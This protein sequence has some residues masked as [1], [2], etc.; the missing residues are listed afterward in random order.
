MLAGTYLPRAHNVR[1]VAISVAFLHNWSVYKVLEAATWRS[2]PFFTALYIRDLS[3]S[4]DE[5]HSL[6]PFVVAGSVVD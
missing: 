4:L 3:Y 6:G 2:N 5:C 1:G